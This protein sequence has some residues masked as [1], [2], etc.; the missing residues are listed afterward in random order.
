MGKKGRP[1]Q[2]NFLMLQR[3]ARLA[4][5]GRPTAED[6]RRLQDY[7]VGRERY[8]D[9]AL[10]KDD[11][12]VFFMGPK[13]VGKSA[14]LQMVRSERQS[15]LRRLIE[16]APDDLAFSA[17]ANVEASTP[18]LHEAEHNQWLFKSLWDYIL[19]VEILRRESRDLSSI[20]A[21][22]FGGK[23]QKA[24]RRLLQISL[25][26]D[27]SKRNLIERLLQLI[28]EVEVSGASGDTSVT[29]KITIADSS[30]HPGEQLHLLSQVNQV[31]KSLPTLL[32]HD[33]YVLIDDLDLHWTDRP[34]QNSCIAALFTS[35]RH[36][37]RPP[38]L[39]FVVAL[40]ADI[41]RRLPI[42]DKDKTRGSICDMQWD[43]NSVKQMLE[44]RV[45]T[46]LR[47]TRG[48]V[49][50]RLFPKRAFEGWWSIT[51]GLPRE[52]IRLMALSIEE[53]ARRGHSRVEDVDLET[54]KFVFSNE[55][56]DDLASEHLHDYPGLDDLLRKFAGW[57]K[58]FNVSRLKDF[59]AQLL[60]D[61]EDRN[62]RFSWAGG[63]AE[64]PRILAKH[65][66]MSGALLLKASRTA[67]PQR[68]NPSLDLPDDFWL[69]IHPMYATALGLAGA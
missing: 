48:D 61:V 62:A 22:I 64:D 26:D 31:A 36:L 12:A 6:D 25:A 66:L 37:N 39:K 23:P 33:Y 9:R 42:P 2:R 30:A 5:L 41:Y 58:E 35:L 19:S 14:V 57:P 54:A 53:A 60:I 45:A 32:A 38:H 21:R 29:G 8:L 11:P 15:D 27:G 49:W 59:A 51:N 55:R 44:V 20:F 17:L 13:G 24:A 1:D 10:D 18:L 67:R 4:D 56:I 65:L 63:C 34:L 7:Y 52:M 68:F 69:A 47:C 43:E 50:S 28:K 16:I 46:V 40:R 3:D